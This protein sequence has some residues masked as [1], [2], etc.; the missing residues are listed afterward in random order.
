L[1]VG[2]K[3]S[4]ED[5]LSHSN[6]KSDTELLTWAPD[7]QPKTIDYHP[8]HMSRDIGMDEHGVDWPFGWHLVGFWLGS[9][10][11]IS[12]DFCHTLTTNLTQNELII[13]III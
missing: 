6:H 7:E 2:Q 1:E 8:L 9:W 5:C 10:A 11:K 13:I 4:A 3:I 12:A